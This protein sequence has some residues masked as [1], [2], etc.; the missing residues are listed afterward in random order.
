LI[1]M[2]IKPMLKLTFIAFLLIVIALVQFY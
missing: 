2:S 1:A